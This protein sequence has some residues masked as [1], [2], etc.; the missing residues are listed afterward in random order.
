MTRDD[1]DM[2]G[3]R[4]AEAWHEAASWRERKLDSER[5]LQ[6]LVLA[7]SIAAG[8]PAVACYL[9]ARIYDRLKYM[10]APGDAQIW[11]DALEDQAVRSSTEGEGS[12]GT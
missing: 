3:C 4:L 1:L 11:L 10:G 6:V 9:G 2:H 12:T 7:T 8:D 5:R